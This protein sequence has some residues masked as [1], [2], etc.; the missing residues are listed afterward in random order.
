M[1]EKITVLAS[2]WSGG[3]ELEIDE[4][5][6]T[7]VAHLKDARQQVVD[8]LDTVEEMVDHSG[9]DIAIIPEIAEAADIVAARQATYAAQL[10]QKHAAELSRQTVRKL[11]SSGIPIV[12]VAEL[13]EVSPGR[14]S[15]LANS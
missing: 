11:R 3:W 5:H 7:Q 9:W 14:V 8:Y 12:D 15:Q 4:N 10:A 13:M 6:H 2:R 1:S